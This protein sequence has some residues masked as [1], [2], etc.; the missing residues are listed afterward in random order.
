VQL[1]KRALRAEKS[2][3]ESSQRACCVSLRDMGV[4]V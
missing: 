1:R 3:S 2:V 4:G